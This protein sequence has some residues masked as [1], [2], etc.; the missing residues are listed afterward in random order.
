MKKALLNKI[1]KGSYYFSVIKDE[2]KS[3]GRELENKNVRH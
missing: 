1:V 2:V 3:K